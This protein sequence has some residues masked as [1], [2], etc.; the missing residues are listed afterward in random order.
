MSNQNARRNFTTPVGRFVN[1]NLY[2]PQTKD[3]DGKPLLVKNGPNVGQPTQKFYIAIAI[4]KIP[5]GHWAA[6]PRNPK[7]PEQESWGEAI[8]AAGNLAFAQVAQ[9][10]SFAWKVS[11]GDSTIP[12]KKGRKPCDNEGWPGNW[13]LHCSGSFAPKCYNNDGSAVLVEKDAIKPGY[14]VQIAGN[15]G[16]NASSQNP[17]VFVN[18]SM[19]SLQGYGVEIVSGPDASAVGFGGA[20]LPAG[21]S[22]TPVGGFAPAAA[23]QPPAG[24]PAVAAPFYPPGTLPVPPG[25]PVPPPVVAAPPPLPVTPHPAFLAPPGAPAAPVYPPAAAP[26][27]APFPPAAAPQPPAPPAPARVMLPAA[28]GHSYQALVAAGWTDATLR[29]AGMMA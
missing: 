8:W 5:G 10:P 4:P 21:A 27:V 26:V 11:D 18:P 9:S 2:T 3:A 22:V 24:H 13:I 16:G 1:G 15:V 23:P 19:V 7:M 17:G 25:A 12:N 14:Y 6:Y 29:A 28:G 20:A